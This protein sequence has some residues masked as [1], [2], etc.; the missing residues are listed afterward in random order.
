[1]GGGTCTGT[2]LVVHIQAEDSRLMV[3]DMH[4]AIVIGD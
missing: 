2:W 1:M 3:D 4:V